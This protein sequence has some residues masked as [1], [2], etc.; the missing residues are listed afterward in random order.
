M[1]T[2]RLALFCLLA[3]PQ[4]LPPEQADHIS[5]PTS[6][7]SSKAQQHFQR[8]VWW[9]H[10]FGYEDAID[11]FQAAQ[12]AD[13]GFAMA[14]WGEAMAHSQPLWYTENVSAARRV[15]TLFGTGRA[16][17]PREQGYLDAVKVLFS[18]GD[19]SARYEAYASAMEKLAASHPED[20]EAA[21]FHAL[22]L[23]ATVP[24]GSYD[25]AVRQRAS[26]IAAGVLAKN[27]KHPGATHLMLH[28]NDDREHAHLAL[29]AARTYARMAPATSHALHMPAHIFLQLGL[30]KEA[31]LSDEASFTASELRVRRRKLSIVQRDY[32]SLSW[33][34]YAYLQRG[35]FQ[36]AR[37]AW[38]PIQDAIKIADKSGSRVGWPSSEEHA[39]TDP[40]PPDAAVLRSDFATMRAIHVVE[41]GQWELMKGQSSFENVDELLAVGMSAAGL[42]DAARAAAVHQLFEKFAREAKDPADRTLITIMEAQAAA[43]AA[44]SGKS[45]EAALKE[46]ARAASIERTLPRPL[47]RP[48]PIKPSHELYG[49][50]L[51]ETDRP[52]EAIG[53]FEHALYRAANRARS[54][55]GLARAQADAGDRASARKTYAR[56]LDLWA[57]ADEG[58]PEIAEARKVLGLQP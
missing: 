45:V 44:R 36:N 55:I 51:L 15:L 22:A 2:A 37:R 53:E 25:L 27:P 18:D 34:A 26:A 56:F 19:R 40:A 8:G 1:P 58:R 29:E 7:K 11:E 21:C 41:T 5:F 31:V 10:N 28:A 17:S 52:R 9:L 48:R 35:Q 24:R 13:T 50:L 3:L 23:L 16:H 6:T 43:A 47:G 54:L 20:L 42:G 32:H 49:E 39:H 33:L 14:Y 46:A 4:A 38:V 57:D 30:W 12:L